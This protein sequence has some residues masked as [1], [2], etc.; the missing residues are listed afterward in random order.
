MTFKEFKGKV[1]DFCNEH[2]DAIE[3]GTFFV[4]GMVSTGLG[5]MEGRKIGRTEGYNSAV[6]DVVATLDMAAKKGAIMRIGGE[7]VGGNTMLA[8]IA[9][10][11]SK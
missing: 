5:I 4:L 1:V 2:S 7:S 3:C 8:R 11:A 6:Q 9:E 10:I